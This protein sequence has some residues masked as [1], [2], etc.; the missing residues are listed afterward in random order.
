MMSIF[1]GCWSGFSIC[2]C[3]WYLQYISCV[4]AHS[5]SYA[6]FEANRPCVKSVRNIFYFCFYLQPWRPSTSELISTIMEVETDP[7]VNVSVVTEESVG[8]IPTLT[9][10]EPSSSG[11]EPSA[12]SSRRKRR[13]NFQ[14]SDDV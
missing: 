1:V 14:D 8:T 11:L 3:V 6:Y 5:T 10:P 4:S 2:I 13:L 12:S 7:S 9:V